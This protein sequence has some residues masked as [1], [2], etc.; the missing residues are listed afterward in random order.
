MGCLCAKAFPD[1]YSTYYVGTV[2]S[3]DEGVEAQGGE[4]PSLSSDI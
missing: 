1:Y 2:P 4:V 3:L